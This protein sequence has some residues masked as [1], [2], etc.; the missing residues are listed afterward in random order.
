[1]VKIG[2][3]HICKVIFYK[4]ENDLTKNT[5]CKCRG[6]SHGIATAKST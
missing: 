5:I 3:S 2:I 1:M 4:Q 6:R